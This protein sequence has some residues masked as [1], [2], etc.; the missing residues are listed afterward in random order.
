MANTTAPLSEVGVASM[1]ADLLD[2]F[3]FASFDEDAPLTRF[4]AREF[5]YV[6]DE[7]LQ[8]YPWHPAKKRALLEPLADAPAFGWATAYNLPAD[9][10]RVLP[11]RADGYLNG[12]RVAF[13]IEDGKLL[14]DYTK[15]LPIHYIYRLTNMA[16]WRP[17]MARVLAS[18][19]A[20]YA[21][22]RVTGKAEY[23]N[24]AQAEYNRVL[25]EAT[26]ADSLERGTPENYLGD[27]DGNVFSARGI[28]Y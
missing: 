5:G 19:L 26:H 16:K 2:E 6:R 14:C 8:L 27:D 3:N 15:A 28:E 11:L 9:A 1:A 18:R 25:F 22:T 24:K 21:S 20:M 13:E 17:L 12:N 23:F 7:V 4:F 10:I